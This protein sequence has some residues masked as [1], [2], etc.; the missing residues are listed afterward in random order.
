MI[1]LRLLNYR[2]CLLALA[3]RRAIRI[4]PRR[5]R[6]FAVANTGLPHCAQLLKRVVELEALVRDL[7]ERL[8][9]NS[10]NSS[11]PHSANP[12]GA[13]KPVV[14]ARSGRRPGG[15]DGDP[16]HH[17]HR[18]PPE[19]VKNIVP[20]L[21]TICTQC[22]APLPAERGLGD[23]EPSWHQVAELPDLTANITE[24]KGHARTCPCCGHLNRGQI[25]PEIRAHVIG[26]RL[27]AVMS[28]FSGRH[29]FGRRAVEEVVE[30]VFEVPTS[31]GSISALEAEKCAALAGPYQQA[32]TAVREAAVKNTDESG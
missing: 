22:Q 23:P 9:Q 1:V 17:R 16:G 15:Q 27:A 11:I 14:K 24:H 8:N 13:P 31:L 2:G 18:R 20:Y 26:P 10:S 3:K 6:P 29:H 12:L 5:E 4:V 28:Y 25:P 7:Q 19:R 30:T 32:Q 21:P